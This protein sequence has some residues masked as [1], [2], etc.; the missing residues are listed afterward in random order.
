MS[1]LARLRCLAFGIL[2]GLV[3]L[4]AGVCDCGGKTTQAGGLEV[5]I[6]TDM[7][8]PASFDTVLVDVEQQAA[9]GGWQSPLLHQFYVIPSQIMLPTT[10]SIAAGSS[11]YQEALITVTGLKGGQA[12]QYVVQRVVQT[13]VP[14]D[15][16]A[17]VLGVLASVCAGKLNC[18][19]ADSC[20]PAS[21]GDAAP[22]AC[23]TDAAGVATLPPSTSS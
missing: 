3:L 20:Q 5:I 13:Q 4:V 8:T 17:A 15:R 6:S 2:A 23:G 11:P 21:A 18:P 9:G 10:I 7:A 14:S 19:M 12:G 22:G 1:K 16:V